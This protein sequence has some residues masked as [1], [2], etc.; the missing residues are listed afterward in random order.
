MIWTPFWKSFWTE[1]DMQTLQQANEA[2]PRKSLKNHQFLH[3]FAKA[4]VLFGSQMR[5][6]NDTSC[7]LRTVSCFNPSSNQFLMT[8]GRPLGPHFDLQNQSKP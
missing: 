5:L 3:D 4:A 2:H 1:F 6:M 7:P 8:F